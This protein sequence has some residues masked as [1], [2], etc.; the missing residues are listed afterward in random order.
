MKIKD[1]AR[2]FLGNFSLGAR[3]GNSPSAHIQKTNIQLQCTFLRLN[4]FVSFVQG[5]DPSAH[6]RVH[7][8]VQQTITKRLLNNNESSAHS[9]HVTLSPNEVIL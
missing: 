4:V 2:F 7:T 9:A 6:I 1:H 8:S 5:C 3:L